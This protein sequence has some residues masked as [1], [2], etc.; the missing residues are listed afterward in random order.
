MK[1]NDAYTLWLAEV[2]VLWEKI[3]TDGTKR[4]TIQ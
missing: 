2:R 3:Y 4:G 1:K